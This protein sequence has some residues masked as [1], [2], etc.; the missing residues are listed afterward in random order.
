VRRWRVLLLGAA[1][2]GA[3]AAPAHRMVVAANPIAAQ[4]GLDVLRAGGN[5][6]DAAVAVQAVLGLVEPQASGLGGGALLLHY[7][8]STRQITA[9]DGRETAPAAASPDLFLGSDKRPLPFGA[10][11]LSGRSVGVPGTIAMLELAHREHGHLPWAGLF[12]PAIGLA[13]GGFA[14]TPRVAALVSREAMPLAAMPEPKAYLLAG[15][16]P[17]PGAALRNPAYAGALR[18]V[19]K[20]GSAALRRGPIAEAIVAAVR[21]DP[22]PGLMTI[23]D[24]AAYQ[25]KRRE[26]V[27]GPYRALTVCTAG[28]PSAGGTMLLETLG[29]LGHFDVA[30]LP[31]DGADA[32]M[33]LTESERL[34]AADRDAYGGDAD[35]VSV[36]SA[37]LADPAYVTARAQAIDPD[38]AIATVRAG[39][40]DWNTPAPPAGIGPAEHGTSD[41][42]IVDAAG[43]AVSMTTTI[44]Y[45]FGSHRMASG[46]F[47]N[48]ELTDFSF[49]P[50]RDG[51][52]VANR[53]AAGKR[54]R[55]SMAPSLVLDASRKLVAV[56]GSAGGSRI[57]LYIAQ[58]IVGV[59][60][61]KL[62]PS[63]ALALGH[64]GSAGAGALLETGT[65]AAALAPALAARGEAV[66][67]EPLNSGTALITL[68]PTGLAGAADPRRDGAAR[69]E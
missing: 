15:G 63:R 48:N 57:P 26:P 59:I 50:L 3:A 41:I 8:A 14:L 10:A 16:L 20:D 34:A 62:D 60:D 36:P 46:F 30:A 13:E 28:P 22:L 66:S 32:A 39:N 44:E 23:D 68:G 18:A 5:A 56:V 31:P 25:P 7:E 35:F 12:Q 29:L 42:A 51:R 17:Q 24:L 54:P 69:G 21:R 52:P 19:A 33:L 47:L 38:R 45:E 49:L 37:G 27:C 6:M 64:A 61:W 2:G 55:S 67:L 43:N 40:P 1:L 4:A 65:S 11:V 53:V 58:A 9:Y